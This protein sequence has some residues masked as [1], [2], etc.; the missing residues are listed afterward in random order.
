MQLSY[1]IEKYFTV[2]L[3][4]FL[5]STC[6]IAQHIEDNPQNL[7]RLLKAH[8]T[9]ERYGLPDLGRGD[10]VYHKWAKYYMHYNTDSIFSRF[11]KHGGFN[12]NHKELTYFYFG[13][14]TEMTQEKKDQEIAKLEKIARKYKSELLWKEIDYIKAINMPQENDKQ[15]DAKIIRLRQLKYRAEKHKDTLMQIRYMDRIFT[16]LYYEGQNFNR[17]YFETIEEASVIVPF[18]DKITD[19]QFIGRSRLYT[20]IGELYYRHGYF[21][22]AIP[23]LKKAAEKEKN[24]FTPLNTLGLYYRNISE[25]DSSD[26]YFRAILQRTE[27]IHAGDGHEAIAICNLGKNYVL[28]G[29]YEKAQRLFE[30]AFPTLLKYRDYTFGAGVCM[31]LG[32]CY[33]IRNNLPKTKVMLDSA[34]KYMMYHNSFVHSGDWYPLA[35]QY[36]ARTG[37]IT[38]AVAYID[39]ASAQWQRLRQKYNASHIF[40]A[41]KKLYEAEREAD[42][43]ALAIERMQKEKYMA[44]LWAIVGLIVIAGIFYSLYRRLRKRKNRALYQ[45]MVEEERMKTRLSETKRKI[46]EQS[47][48]PISTPAQNRNNTETGENGNGIVLLQ[49][50]EILVLNE[51]FYT[52][53]ALNRKTLSDRLNTNETYLA[54]IIRNEYG[55]TVSDYINTLRLN[56]AR[57]LLKDQAIESIKQ[58]AVDS[59][60]A[61]YKYFHQLFSNRFGMSPSEFRK[62]AQGE[63]PDTYESSDS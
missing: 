49:K 27:L 28:R 9:S 37:N 6:L 2:L 18:L 45:R 48:L 14:M 53:T 52:D 17:S 54:N 56:H 1:R 51:Q 4:H 35:A 10:S 15:F 7:D 38:K 34:Y 12:P 22:L 23:F 13:V 11:V 44:L 43:Q 20:F 62:F 59:G 30:Q 61:T 24:S 31:E 36:Y 26:Y 46:A 21:E 33:F 63:N 47:S 57:K 58:I 39:S 42:K 19:E 32:K 25:L 40:N 3:F 29:D 55:Q 16:F 8:S 41:E 5:S 60:F 50:L